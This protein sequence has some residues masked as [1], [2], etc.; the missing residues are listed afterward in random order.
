MQPGHVPD[1][2]KIDVSTLSAEELRQL[3][4][5][6]GGECPAWCHPR[7]QRP[8]SRSEPPAISDL[9]RLCS[10]C[11]RRAAGAS[12]AA[13]APGGGGTRGASCTSALLAAFHPLV[14]AALA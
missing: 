13:G 7:W 1:L 9:S 2:T 8:A 4:S 5:Q 11:R 10:L 14:W 6:C 12:P 3:F